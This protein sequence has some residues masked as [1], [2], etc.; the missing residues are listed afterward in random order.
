[1]LLDRRQAN[2][3]SQAFGVCTS[4]SQWRNLF[5]NSL[6]VSSL[7]IRSSSCTLLFSL[8]SLLTC[9]KLSLSFTNISCLLPSTLSS[10]FSMISVNGGS[11]WFYNRIWTHLD[12]LTA[13]S[14][15]KRTPFSTAKTSLAWRKVLSHNEL[16]FRTRFLS[17]GPHARWGKSQ[18]KQKSTPVYHLLLL[19][20]VSDPIRWNQL[21]LTLRRN[22]DQ[23]HSCRVQCSLS[24]VSQ[25]SYRQPR[26]ISLSKPY[27]VTL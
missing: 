1:M 16:L 17:N 7:F 6:S 12:L 22:C 13:K 8:S 11:V 18:W 4:D 20:G 14:Y 10:K 2:K 27:G 24:Q 3:I 19:Y 23:C 21:I 15:P 25:I 26:W 5:F 9:A